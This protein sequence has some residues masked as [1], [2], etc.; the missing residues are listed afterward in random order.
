MV[1]GLCSIFNSL[2][3][4]TLTKPD[5]EVLTHERK[6]CYWQLSV[7][8]LMGGG[9]Q[10]LDFPGAKGHWDLSL[11]KQTWPRTVEVDPSHGLWARSMS[12]LLWALTPNRTIKA[13]VGAA[14][15]PTQSANQLFSILKGFVRC[16]K[17]ELRDS[18]QLNTIYLPLY[19]SRK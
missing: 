1:W 6:W 7:L 5:L 14:Q 10:I 18:N 8:G 19:F 13:S 12:K 17:W 16:L 3:D 9:G 11:I 4:Y 15:G 2:N